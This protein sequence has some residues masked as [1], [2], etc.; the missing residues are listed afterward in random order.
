MAKYFVIV[1]GALLIFGS[2]NSCSEDPPTGGKD[3]CDTCH[4]PWDTC[5]TTKPSTNDTTSHD[6]I[7]TEYSIPTESNLTGCWVFDD[8]TIYVNGTRLYMYDG[9]KWTRKPLPIRITTREAALADYPFFAFSKDDMWFTKGI[10]YH[11][12]NGVV[13]EYRNVS[14]TTFNGIKA[15]WGTSSSDMFF[16]GVQGNISHF[17]GTTFTKMTSPTTKNLRSVWGTSHNDVWAAGYNF[18]TDE[19]VLIHYDGTSWTEDEFSTSG[20]TRQ[21]GIGTVWDVDSSGHNVRIIAGT[22]VFRKTDNGPWRKDTAEIGN[23]L[24]GGSYNGIGA[25]GNTPNDLMAVGSW[26][27]ISHWNGKTWKKYDELYNYGIVD[28]GAAAFS[29]NINTACA[30]GRK[31]GKSWITVGRRK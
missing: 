1:L 9:G 25:F 10:L 27:F 21:F 19:S 4:V 18:S 8:T 31:S 30:V 23:S 15:C 13:D 16:V 24:G 3:S 28:Y 14:D 2:L 22:R 6:F 20:Q 26:G 17:D 5:D 7:W 12:T 11:Y 29:I